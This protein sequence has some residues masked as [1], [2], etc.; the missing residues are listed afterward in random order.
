[1]RVI[2]TKS[3]AP[4]HHTQYRILVWRSKVRN[5]LKLTI[6]MGMKYMVVEQLQLE[7]AL[8]GTHGEF[9]SSINTI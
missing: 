5:A 2:E 1:M 6:F 9:F 4:S 7:L 8:M 3:L